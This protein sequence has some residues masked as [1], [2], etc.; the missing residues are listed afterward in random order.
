MLQLALDGAIALLLVL[1]L[2][3]GVRLHLALRALRRDN[4]DLEALIGAM[5]GATE[6]A[7]EALEGL[8]RTAGEAAERLVADVEKAQRLHDDLRFLCD[9]GERV[10]DGLAGQ[11]QASRTPSAVRGVAAPSRPPAADLER[12]LRALR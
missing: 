8:K 5:D 9:R 12:T 1:T 7:R 2:G 6:R 4:T 3:V 11:I 10:A